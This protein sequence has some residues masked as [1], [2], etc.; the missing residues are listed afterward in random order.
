M[1]SAAPS[2]MSINRRFRY[3]VIT[4]YVVVVGLLLWLFALQWHGYWDAYEAKKQFIVVQAALR[5]QAA[6]SSERRP[7]VAVLLGHDTNRSWL[8]LQQQ[9]RHLTDVHME[10][11]GAALR[12]P[13]CESCAALLPEWGRIKRDLVSARGNLDALRGTHFTDDDVIDG[14]G[15]LVGLILNLSTIA[16]ASATGVIRENADVQNYLLLARLA[17]LMR[18]QAGLISQQFAPSLVSHRA[19]TP[20]EIQSVSATLGKIEQ[21]RQLLQPNVALLTKE[22]QADY[23]DMHQRFFGQGVAMLRTLRTN[24]ERP[25]GPGITLMQLGEQY[26]PLVLP[27]NRFRDDAL[28]LASRTID[29]SLR[30]HLI[31][32]IASG[33]LAAL[34]TGLLVAMIRRFRTRVIVPFSEAQRFILDIAHGD[35]SVQL[36]AKHYGSEVA[37]LFAALDVLKNNDLQRRELERERRRLISELKA[38]AE[39]DPLTGLLNRR[40]FESRANVLLSDKRNTDAFVSLMMLDIDFFKRVNDTFGHESGDKALVRLASFCREAVRSEDVV[41]RFGGEEF[42]ILLRVHEPAQAQVIAET[43]RV[44]LHQET[45]TSTDGTVFR[46]TVSIGIASKACAGDGAL[47]LEELMRQ[48][49]VL[50]YRAKQNGRDRIETSLLG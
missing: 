46:F 49:D 12:D 34:L 28:A 20:Q 33:L 8:E 4:V 50:L 36:P 22:L 31:Y 43:L 40:A 16:E 1:P 42:V 15:H 2:G 14:F 29:D 44:R 26:G 25:G 45:V 30:W 47:D 32:L 17:G 21:L 48:A 19:L 24:G 10:T 13:A 7:T 23:A 6:I 11:L 27:I 3:I 38:M 35:V 39:T 18:E 9:A 5:A 37:K 41:A